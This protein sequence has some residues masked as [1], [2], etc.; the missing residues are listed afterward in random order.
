MGGAVMLPAALSSVMNMFDE[1]A[2]RNKA[3]GIWGGLG[4]GGG[5]FGLIMGGLLTRYAGWQFVFFLNLPIGV[6]ILTLAPRVVPDSRIV[7]AGRR[8]DVAGAVAGTGALVPVAHARR[9]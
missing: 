4:A 6:T 2:E 8:F 9:C 3:L 7:S 1:G 5:T